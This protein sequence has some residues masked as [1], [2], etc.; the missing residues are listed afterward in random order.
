MSVLRDLVAQI[1]R[2][3]A[4]TQPDTGAQL[5]WS[6]DLDGVNFVVTD[7]S[8]ADVE[9]G[10]A[11]TTVLA[12]FVALSMLEEQGVA[13]RL[14]HGFS[15]LAAAVANCDQ[16][17]ADV[18]GLPEQF[19]GS[20]DVSFDAHTRSEKFRAHPST[21]M[22]GQSVRVR[23]RG[24]FIEAAEQ[25]FRATPAQWS[26]LQ[27][28]TD[29]DATPQP[30]RDETTNVQLVGRLLAAADADPKLRVGHFSD[31]GWTVSSPDK[32]GVRAD[33]QPNG[34]LLLSPALDA[35]AKP[36]LLA[37]RWGQL[38]GQHHNGVL[39]VK[40][41][42]ISLDSVALDGVREVLKN[43]RIPAE[44][45][46][47]FLKTP[48]AFLDAALIDLDLG[49]S[50]R[51]EGV[52]VTRMLQFGND[53]PTAIDWF[54]SE[55]LPPASGILSDLLRSNE[56]IDAF[57]ALLDSA[58]IH[59][60][61]TVEFREHLIDVSDIDDTRQA[62]DVAR[63]Q[64][65]EPAAE[66]PSG[67][68]SGARLKVGL[69]V[70]DAG[71]QIDTLH[72]KASLAARRSQFDGTKLARSPFPHQ[73]TGIEWLLGMISAAQDEDPE[74]LYRLQGAL[75]ADDMGLGKTFMA[76]AAIA[77]H[78][79]HVRAVAGARAV[80]PTLVV[81]PLSLLENW[82]SE[83]AKSFVHSPFSDVVVLQSS[84]DLKQFVRQGHGR[85]TDQSAALLDERGQM[86]KE[87]LRLSLRV[88]NAEGT[89]RLDQPNRLVLTTYDTLRDY[90]FS[91]A[92][93]D[94]GVV[95]F[96]EAQAIKNPNAMRTRAAKGLRAT[97]KLVATGTPVEN[98]LGDFWCLLD[99]A[100]PGLLGDWETFRDT[101]ITPVLDAEWSVRDQLRLELGQQLRRAVG[102]F[103]LRRIK[104]DHLDGL[105]AKIVHSPFSDDFDGPHSVALA[106]RMPERQRE[107]YDAVLQDRAGQALV[108]LARLR[109]VSLHPELWIGGT[110][111]ALPD[112]PDDAL[113]QLK[114]SGKLL[115]LVS[116][117]DSIRAAG[118]KAIIF[119]ISKDLQLLLALWIG[120]VYGVRPSIVNGDTSA[121]SRPSSSGSSPRSRRE[122]IEHFEATP[123]FNVIIM[124]PIAAGTGLTVVGANHVIHLERHW[125]PAK[126]AQATDRAYRIGQTRDV[127]VY[128]PASVHPTLD[129]FD[130]L[131]DRLLAS[132]VTIKDA[133]MEQGEVT[134]AD[135]YSAFGLRESKGD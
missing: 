20:L 51:V 7:G 106:R 59:G 50:V 8:L 83:V 80:R 71:E 97:F 54:Q 49:F 6:H 77:Q 60:A 133:V 37:T 25:L 72:E 22:G 18:L 112:T 84:R 26:A 94:W 43:R 74:D 2:S 126:E 10:A 91:M 95:V 119:A 108:T 124:S 31:S 42:L 79:D 30:D 28:I 55:S 78:N 47:Q 11:S 36:E 33:L 131:L 89:S 61:T 5:V 75:L 48:S 93:I 9:R 1:L 88:G 45:V 76:L 15:I 98:S 135:F 103:M 73:I 41:H 40:N 132:K 67:G 39:R 114:A 68:G 82:E 105:P 125:N 121:T 134:E 118:E 44:Q 116:A 86:P 14:P 38:S 29:H 128:F 64:V 16:S 24:G 81:A 123:G 69:I 115:G 110:R 17:I 107:A 32:V 104:E 12:Q 66:R 3:A 27:A 46:Q 62:V 21:R 57:E 70:K 23:G 90:Q 65:A 13:K 96:D 129:S 63:A 100:Q 101:W 120:Y 111:P 34:D 102:P 35:D 85:E 53:N 92:Q 117:L 109:A 58:V 130:V 56:D 122:L 4:A 19:A 113:G 87:Q 99:A 52:G 127:H